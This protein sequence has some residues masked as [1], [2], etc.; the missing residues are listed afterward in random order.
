[1][2]GPELPAALLEQVPSLAR[3]TW[4]RLPGLSRG[5]WRAS[6]G[7]GPALVVR[8]AGPVEAAATERAAASRVA[9]PFVAADAGWVVTGWVE[10]QHVGLL[11]LSRPA[12]LAEVA[13][14][15]HR[16]H[17][18]VLDVPARPLRAAREE[19]RTRAREVSP[20]VVEALASF[21]AAAD[22][23]EAR[24]VASPAGRVTGHLDVVANVLRTPQGLR[25]IDFEYVASTDPDRELGQLVWE[26]ELSATSAARLVDAY[27]PDSGGRR[28]AH[29]DQVAG[30]A[31]VTGVTWTSWGAS[32]PSLRPW[33]RRAFERLRHHWTLAGLVDDTP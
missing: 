2:T 26:G 27:W 21:E 8:A 18:V 13:Q 7:E 1:V 19:Y 28:Q 17:G 14:L 33:T 12:V 9:P 30:W 5:A 31:F 3:A 20:D 10:A 22:R 6:T 25:L 16:W 4:S 23:R 32:D 24:L 15:L 11:E 29:L